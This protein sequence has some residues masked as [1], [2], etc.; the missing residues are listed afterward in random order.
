MAREENKNEKID[1]DD[2]PPDH[3][4]AC[5]SG[6]ARER[7]LLLRGSVPAVAGYARQARAL[8][9]DGPHWSDLNHNE[10]KHRARAGSTAF[11]PD[12]ARARGHGLDLRPWLGVR[13]LWP[14][15]PLQEH[16][17]PA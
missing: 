10:G 9:R 8:G 14:Q 5:T 17:Q 16:P 12:P 7:E 11:R 15:P 3:G 13:G 2:L 1:E 4:R 6:H